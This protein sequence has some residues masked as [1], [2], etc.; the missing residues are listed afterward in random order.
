MTDSEKRR[1]AI[2]EFLYDHR[3][4]QPGELASMVEF[5][6]SEPD[7]HTED[8]WRGTLRGLKRD[9][10][11]MLAESYEFAGTSALITDRGRAFVE[12]RRS[13]QAAEQEARN[14]RRTDP[15]LRRAAATNGLLRWLYEQDPDGGKGL[16]VDQVLSTEHAVFEGDRLPENLI[17]RVAQYLQDS[18]LVRGDKGVAEIEGP[19]TVQ[20]T[21]LG[22][23]CIESGGDV[24]SYL[25][26]RDARS[27]T[28]TNFHGPVSGNVSWN[29]TH[30]TQTATTTGTAGDE[31]AVLV[32]AIAEA[33]PVLG[34][35]EDQAAAVRRNTQVIEAELEQPEPDQR[36]VTNLV[37]RTLDIVT[38]ASSSALGLLL[39]G[40]AKELMK[41]AGLPIE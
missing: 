32:R 16:Y 15:A 5:L 41:S 29:S 13:H 10:L 33:V 34:L 18:G 17:R 6:G 31:L 30:V 24:A 37:G 3:P 38:G 35:S 21:P 22:Q 4:H 20:I 40:Y 25:R 12:A 8:L 7:D 1:I 11:I 27:T 9:D 36:T 23:D 2:L 19:I 26:D 28:I 39:T 14:R